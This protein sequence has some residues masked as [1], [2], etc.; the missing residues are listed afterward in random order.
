MRSSCSALPMSPLVS[1]RA[2]LHSIIGSPVRLRSSITMLALISA[3][4]LRSVLRVVPPAPVQR[5][6][7]WLIVPCGRFLK[8]KGPWAPC[9]PAL[10]RFVSR[11]LDE[12]VGLDD[13]LDHL[14]A[15]F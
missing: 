5:G 2:F 11:N 10:F 1:A 7:P 13:L 15:A 12:L 3:I 6:G 4:L 14:A 9:R 8:T